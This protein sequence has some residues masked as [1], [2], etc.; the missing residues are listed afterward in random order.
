MS[1]PP[2]PKTSGPHVLVRCI[3]KVC[4]HERWVGPYEV[5]PGDMP[6]CEKCSNV[7]V[8]VKAVSRR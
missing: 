8:A 1:P 5:Q 4:R 7:M 3:S 2:I 6:F